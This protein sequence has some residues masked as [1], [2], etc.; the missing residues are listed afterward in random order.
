MKKLLLLLI[1]VL[2]FKLSDAQF[3]GQIPEP[4]KYDAAKVID[5][6]YGITIYEKLNFYTGGDSVRNDKKGYACQG[7]MEDIYLTGSSIHKGFY[8]DGHLK[9][10]KNFYPNGNVERSF[11]LTDYKKCNMQL[12]YQDGKLKSDI[13]Y[14]DGNPQVWTDYYPN[15][16]I[17]YTEENSKSME[18]LVNRKSYAEDGKPQELF[19]L[20]DPKKKIYSKKEYYENGNIKSEGPMIYNPSVIDY[21]KDG[22]WKEYD[23]SG[24]LTATE[25]W[26]KGEKVSG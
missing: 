19:E 1:A 4:T 24:K 3:F 23:E 9:T 21:Q 5:P 2:Y 16:Q 17:E 20:T 7:W 22:V 10:Y 25:K 18:Y 12:F 8:E 6:D 15:G 11:K 14:Y 26:V 13:T